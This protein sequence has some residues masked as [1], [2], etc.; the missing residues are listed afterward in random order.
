MRQTLVKLARRPLH[1]FR[2]F[3]FRLLG[4]RSIGDSLHSSNGSQ[5][6]TLYTD[7]IYQRM[8]DRVCLLESH[9]NWRLHG[10]PAQLGNIRLEQ[11]AVLSQGAELKAMIDK[12]AE[13]C[14]D[15]SERKEAASFLSKS[16]GEAIVVGSYNLFGR[17][18]EPF[19]R[20]K[21]KYLADPEDLTSVSWSLEGKNSDVFSVGVLPFLLSQDDKSYDAIWLGNC[22]QRSAPLQRLLILQNAMRLLKT[23]GVISG[24]SKVAGDLGLQTPMNWEL[25]TALDVPSSSLSISD[26]TYTVTKPH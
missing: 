12:V 1:L 6:D 11:A 22:L 18:A 13:A 14:F 5:N 17:H 7:D 15:D 3:S 26:K 23:G 8:M 10:L 9:V 2:K 4:I 16:S 24:V 25:L 20:K 19:D 21:V